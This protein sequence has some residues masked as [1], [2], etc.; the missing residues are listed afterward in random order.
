MMNIELQNM[1][2]PLS[3]RGINGAFQRERQRMIER[4]K[5]QGIVEPKILSIMA[6]T[7]RHIF[8][9][10]ALS[11]HAYTDHAL[12]IGYGQTISQPYIVACMTAALLAQN[13]LDNVLEIGTGCGYQ[14]AVLAQ[15]VGK[16]Y[17]VERIESLLLKARERLAT[18]ALYNIDFHHADGSCGWK[19][20]APYQGI[21]V[22]AA[23]E[24]IPA[25]LLEQLAIGGRLIMPIGAQGFAQ[26]LV[27]IIRTRS[28]YEQHDLETVSFVPLRKGVS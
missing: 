13:R 4:L 24:Q 15:L 9:D 26:K 1:S 2:S 14:T 19:E 18:L 28:G 8:I 21:I 17:S 6:K 20:N 25:D 11:S 23:P 12:P 3:H 22:T 5:T 16:V 27:K 7:P 10:E